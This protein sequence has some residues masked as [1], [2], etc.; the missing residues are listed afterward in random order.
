M[1]SGAVYTF[2]TEGDFITKIVSF[3]GADEDY[4]G[5]DVAISGDTIVVGAYRDDD[6]GSS[7]GSAYIYDSDGTFV[8]K[9]VAPDGSSNEYFGESVAVSQDIVAIGAEREN[10]IGSRGGAVYL[11]ST[12]GEFIEKKMAPDGES[13]DI[14]G[15]DVAISGDM[16]AVGA[17]QDDDDGSSSG[18]AYLFYF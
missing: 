7:S 3:D 1:N 9:I 11:F 10:E 16:F 4:F 2:S 17:F 6:N 18:S 15:C 12:S 14:F 5:F 8:A 13:N